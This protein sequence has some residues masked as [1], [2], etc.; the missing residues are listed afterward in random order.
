[1]KTYRYNKFNKIL[2]LFALVFIALSLLIL[3]KTPSADGYEFSIYYAYPW[4]FWFFIIM[5][6]FI[7]QLIIIKNAISENELN[8]WVFGVIIILITD[9]ILLFLPIV[10]SY[11]IYGRGDVLTHVG[12]TKDILNSGHISPSNIY[13]VE[14]ILATTIHGITNIDLGT[15]TI[16]LPDILFLLF[17]FWYTLFILQVFERKVALLI[18][19]IS[20]LPLFDTGT[21]FYAP[22]MLSFYFVPFILYIFYILLY[23]ELK[24]NQIKYK[25]IVI[26]FLA[27][28]CMLFFHP[29]TFLY[30]IIIILSLYVTGVISNKVYK[31]RRDGS[32]YHF[33]KKFGIFLLGLIL[34][35][36]IV[37]SSNPV[38]KSR[39]KQL[40]SNFFGLNSLLRQYTSVLQNFNISVADIIKVLICKFGILFILAVSSTILILYCLAKY[41]RKFRKEKIKDLLLLRYRYLIFF[42]TGFAFFS[43]W[44][45]ANMFIQFLSFSR[46]FKFITF[47]SVPLA[48]FLFYISNKK[49]KK[50][51]FIFAI[52]LV[53]L[54]CCSVIGLYPSH[55]MG[56]QNSQVPYGE[57][58]GMCWFFEH[59]DTNLLIHE[60]GP[61][62]FR[63][64]DA[65]YGTT[66]TAHRRNIIS[67]SSTLIPDH[68]GYHKNVES[69]GQLYDKNTYFI[70]SAAGKFFYEN[71]Y[72]QYQEYWH[73]LIIK[74]LK[75]LM[76]QQIEYI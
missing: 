38:L 46:V 6:L 7:G 61:S 35:S 41:F 29:L 69:T 73:L 4:Y 5:S 42:M 43:M 67:C 2:F 20:A 24:V 17:I 30:L 76:Y 31:N 9:A 3:V 49:Y 51:K 16:A 71:M 33:S 25:Y 10:R 44:S 60:Q 14:H 45:L 13:P 37:Y 62:Q 53:S 1:M 57:Y 19:P 58:V 63:F 23:S 40:L 28:I 48:S 12:Y 55:W 11:L 36:Y 8:S 59:R 47:F 18:L 27:I 39:L 70:I 56:I 75:I 52:V 66:D 68:F 15:L 54:L 26:L 32:C 50:S 65:I 34:V 74:N 22:N 21:I 64:H 72:P